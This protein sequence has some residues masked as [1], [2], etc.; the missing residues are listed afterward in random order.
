MD[1]GV[2]GSFDKVFKDEQNTMTSGK[3]SPNL[4]RIIGRDIRESAGRT[5]KSFM[6]SSTEGFLTKAGSPESKYFLIK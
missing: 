3:R 2:S 5:R 1:E 6:L 4:R